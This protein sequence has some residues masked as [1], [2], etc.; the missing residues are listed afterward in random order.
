MSP[1]EQNELLD[2][3]YQ[4]AAK[5]TVV[6][7]AVQSRAQEIYNDWKDLTAVQMKRS[8]DQ[9]NSTFMRATLSPSEHSPRNMAKK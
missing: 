8:K 4:I 1:T 7:P 2:T 9:F 6:Q 5:S 3:M